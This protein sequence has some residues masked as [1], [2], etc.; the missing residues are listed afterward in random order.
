MSIDIKIEEVHGIAFCGDDFTPRNV[1][2]QIS[3]GIITAIKDTEKSADQ[4]ISPAFFNAHTHIGDTVAM[5][6]PIDGKT[7][8]EIVAPPN[9]IKHQILRSCSGDKL[10]TAMHE[11]M[12]YM[13]SSGT[14]GFADFR[15]G[16]V[17]GVELLKEA[18][19]PGITPVIFGRDGGEV[20]SDGLGLSSAKDLKEDAEKV[21]VARKSGKLVAVHAGEGGVSDIEGA[22]ALEP[23]LIIH[24]TN[25]SDK[26]IRRAA[27]EKIAIVVCPRSNWILGGTDSSKKPKIRRMLDFGCDV[28]LGTDNVMLNAPNMFAEMNFVKTVYKLSSIE[29]MRMATGGFSLGKTSSIIDIGKPA[30]FFTLDQTYVGPFTNSCL[31]TLITRMDSGDIRQ[32]FF[33]Q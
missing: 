2:I 23:D 1:I 28:Y 4:W 25:F 10:K 18:K 26:D 31:T 13:K 15:E 3:N 29:V 27:D 19:V 8:S 30:N 12:K 24:A 5:D 11:T 32:T 33:N 6:I 14:A 17:R 9:G 7:L 20:L 21:S 16:G 22:F